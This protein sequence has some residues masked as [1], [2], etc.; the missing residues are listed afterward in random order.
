MAIKELSTIL[1]EKYGGN[2]PQS[3]EELEQL[4]GVGHKT[5]SVVIESGLR[6]SRI[7]GSTHFH[8]LAQRWGFNKWQVRRAN[9]KRSQGLFPRE[10]LE[11]SSFANHF[12]W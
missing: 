8:R 5:A 7:S 6:R 10:V 2:V 4:P 9:G 3:F 12:L 1:V 11:Q